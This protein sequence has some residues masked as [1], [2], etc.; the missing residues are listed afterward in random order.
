MAYIAGRWGRRFHVG[1]NKIDLGCILLGLVGAAG[2]ALFGYVLITCVSMHHIHPNA[3]IQSLAE[4][5]R[6]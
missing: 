5:F 6:H 1:R 4:I 3:A 2:V